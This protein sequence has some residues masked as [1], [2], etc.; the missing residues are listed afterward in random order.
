M[1]SYLTA[2]LQKHATGVKTWIWH[3]KLSCHV[4][5]ALPE[6][7]SGQVRLQSK[8]M[9]DEGKLATMAHRPRRETQ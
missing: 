1:F 9:N 7:V 4:S 6:K 2:F 3:S 5:P 8:C